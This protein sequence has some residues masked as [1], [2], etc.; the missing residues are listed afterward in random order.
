MVMEVYHTVAFSLAFHEIP[1]RVLNLNE[2]GRPIRSSMRP[3]PSVHMLPMRS[4]TNNQHG[5]PLSPVRRV[6]ARHQRAQDLGAAH[7][8]G[9]RCGLERPTGAVHKPVQRV[10]ARRPCVVRHKVAPGPLTGSVPPAHE[11]PIEDTPARG[12]RV[13]LFP[14]EPGQQSQLVGEEVA[15]ALFHGDVEGGAFGEDL[16]DQV[17]RGC[18]GPAAHLC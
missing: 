17:R 15:E 13:D 9:P 6:H 2:K 3:H 16:A 10:V 8:G 14:E 1:S 11:A 18:C 4:W 12:R 5:P 7:H